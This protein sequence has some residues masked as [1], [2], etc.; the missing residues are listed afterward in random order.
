M[1][2]GTPIFIYFLMHRHL[3]IVGLKEG[4]IYNLELN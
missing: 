3:V 1:A 2:D 4:A